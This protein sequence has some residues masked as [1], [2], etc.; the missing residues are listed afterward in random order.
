ADGYQPR[1]EAEPLSEDDKVYLVIDQA[2]LS[3][4]SPPPPE[5]RTL[6]ERY[7]DKM[8]EQYFE[9]ELMYGPAGLP[10]EIVGVATNVHFALTDAMNRRHG[11]GHLV[12]EDYSYVL[13][14]DDISLFALQPKVLTT[15]EIAEL[16]P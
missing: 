9:Q 2:Q 3:E 16:N 6:A 8:R 5:P 4:V 10:F 15:E 13:D 1:Y 12:F 11:S 14:T 7:V